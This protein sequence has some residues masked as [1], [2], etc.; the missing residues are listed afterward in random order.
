MAT[1]SNQIDHSVALF[2]HLNRMG[3]E[4][5]EIFKIE[6]KDGNP[7]GALPSS[8]VLNFWATARWLESLL[9]PYLTSQQYIN[10]RAEIVA[11]FAEAQKHKLL[12][13]QFEAAN[14]LATYLVL[15]AYNQGFMMTQ[16]VDGDYVINLSEDAEEDIAEEKVSQRASKD[17]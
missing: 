9:A 14:E 11:K 6:L 4:V 13:E 16:R 17:D 1:Y 8:K 15:E 5:N 2:N 7:T 10:K 3:I 12:F